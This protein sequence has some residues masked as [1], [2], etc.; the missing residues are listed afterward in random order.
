MKAVIIAGGQGKRMGTLTEDTP[1]PMITLAGKPILQH[2]IEAVKRYGLNQIIILSGFKGDVIK[3]YFGDGGAYGV[4]IQYLRENAPL[5]TAG[6]VKQLENIVFDD[7]LVLYGDI[8]LDIDFDSLISFH[9]NKKTA[10]T[11]VVHPNDHPADSD[12]LEVDDDGKV[13]AFYNKQHDKNK[14]YRNLV[15]AGVYILSP[16]IFKFIPKN[17]FSD[18]GKDIFPK[19]IKCGQPVSAYHSAEYIKDVGTIERLK[20]V[21]KDVIDGKVARL[22]KKN[23]RRAIF[24]DRDGVLNNE[25]YPLISTEQIKL[26]PGAAEAVKKINKSGLLSIV[27]T[28]QPVIAKGFVSEEDLNIIHGKLESELG[29]NGAYLDKIYY[30]PHHPERGFERERPELKIRCKCRKPETAL[31]KKAI[32]EFNI[33]AGNSF[34]IGDRTV[35]IMTGYK[36]GLTTILVKTGFAGKDNQ[37]DCRPDYTFE[38]LCQAVDFIINQNDSPIKEEAHNVINAGA[39][40]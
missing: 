27:V 9:L 29:D 15:N 19:L 32:E 37:F 39:I 10:A 22:N 3:N 34:L 4:N 13:T 12:L 8:I 30:C 36:A 31:L 25:D 35:D 11:I 7:F 1:K 14:F 18:F 33:D 16:Q 20:E 40:N 24:L 5:G 26:L 28:N 21:E 17:K 6:A 38:N 2:Q 23:K